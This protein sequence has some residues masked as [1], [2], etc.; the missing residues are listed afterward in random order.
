MPFAAG[1]LFENDMEYEVAR[2]LA[3]E[4][5]ASPAFEPVSDDTAVRAKDVMLRCEAV[6][7]TGAPR[8][9][10]N[11]VNDDLL[12]LAKARGMRVVNSADELD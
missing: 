12:A 6:L 1:V 5:I 11:K 2:A 9:S 4:V 8:G 7:D 3:A 10:L